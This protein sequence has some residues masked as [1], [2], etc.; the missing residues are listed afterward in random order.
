[1]TQEVTA[2]CKKHAIVCS[3][4]DRAIDPLQIL[5]HVN[6]SSSTFAM[7]TF[8]STPQAFAISFSKSVEVR[9]NIIILIAKH[10]DLDE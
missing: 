3:E 2:I 9:M 6:C 7:W 1:M 5:E 10:L 8:V 4:K